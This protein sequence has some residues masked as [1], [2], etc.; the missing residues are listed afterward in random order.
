MEKF[1][2]R[3]MRMI[4]ILGGT[5]DPIHCGHLAIA[6]LVREYFNL[7]ELRLIPCCLPPHRKTVASPQQR[8]EMLELAISGEQKFIID[9]REFERSEP[10]WTIDTLRSV[11]AEIENAGL[12]FIMG[13]DVFARINGWKNWQTLLEYT[14]IVYISRKTGLDLPTEIQDW[15]AQHIT[16]D[17]NTISNHPHGFI[18]PLK[19][20]FIASSATEIRHNIKQKLPPQ[21]LPRAVQAYIESH[22]L[23]QF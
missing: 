12:L 5:F 21:Y 22:G 16:H 9:K 10:S 14:H 20:Q 11:R 1:A 8:L 3:A 6:S 23:Y 4:G 2:N 7:D 13:E 18:Y 15:L 19:T 17:V